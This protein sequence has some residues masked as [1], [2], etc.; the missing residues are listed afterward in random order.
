MDIKPRNG[1]QK[2]R[3]RENKNVDGRANEPERNRQKGREE[4]EKN[5]RTCM[6]CLYLPFRRGN[7]TLTVELLGERSKASAAARRND[8]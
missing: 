7:E 6:E 2:E 5:D 1:K 8:E 3:K 4:R